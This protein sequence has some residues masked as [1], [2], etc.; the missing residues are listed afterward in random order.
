MKDMIR[1]AAPDD[2][3]QIDLCFAELLEH[4]RTHIKYTSWQKGVYPTKSTAEQSIAQGNLYV[5]DDGS[6]ICGVIIAG[7]NQPPKFGG[8]LWQVQAQPG[9]VLVINLLCVRPSK[10]RRGIGKSLVMFAAEMAKS[11]GLRA[12][13]LDTGAQNTPAK[14]F[15]EAMG[16]KCAGSNRNFLFYELKI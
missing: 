2:L 13:R 8:I 9:E 7:K 3:E 6:G 4:E 12:V 14:S 15:Y 10:A 11:E 16:F 5:Y 1:K